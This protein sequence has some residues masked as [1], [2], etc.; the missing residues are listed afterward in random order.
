MEYENL[1]YVLLVLVLLAI[2][3]VYNKIK[4]LEGQFFKT[5][6]LQNSID[7]KLKAQELREFERRK[8][9]EWKTNREIE[10]MMSD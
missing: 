9:Q 6:K 2:G 7:D 5:E 3:Y 8:H 1:I 10:E 4:S